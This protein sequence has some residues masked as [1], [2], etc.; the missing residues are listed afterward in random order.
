MQEK[1]KIALADDEV[2]FR[3][4]ISFLLQ[5][6]SN[7]EVVFEASNG[8]ELVSELEITTNFPD[9]IIIDLKMPL[10]N[11]VEATKTI[12]KNF[13]DIKIIALSSYSSDSFISNM[14]EFGAVSYLIKNATPKEMLYA[15]NQVHENG[16]YY[17]Q[18]VLNVLKNDSQSVNTNFNVLDENLLSSR[19][20]QI[21]E[22]I[23]KQFNTSEI[24]ELLFL[25]PRTVDGHRNN[26]LVKTKSKNVAGLVVFAI[27]NNVI[28]IDDFT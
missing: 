19:E 2:L 9:I 23:C 1:I 15:I 21:L 5:R 10:L 11:G 14:I 26:L 22:L 18:N 20:K 25:S 27:Q 17:D 6:E 3:K 13:P 8:V 12:R 7:I 4:A 28:M 24:A 16:F